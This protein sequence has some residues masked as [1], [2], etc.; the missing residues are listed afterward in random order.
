LQIAVSDFV[1]DGLLEAGCEPT[2]CHTVLN[3]IDLNA[4]H[5]D[6][7]RHAV[8][9][10][11]AVAPSTPVVVTVCRLFE[12]KGVKSLIL[13]LDKVRT[14]VPSATLVVVGADP[15]P[16]QRHVGELRELV[17]QLGLDDF[18]TF[19]GR[20]AVVEGLL[21]ASDIFAMPSFEE[22]FGLVYA[23]AMAM[24]RPVV[25]LDNGG[26]REVVVHGVNGLLSQPGDIDGLAANLA[27]LIADPE[28]RRRL[29]DAARRL[30]EQRFTTDRVAAD[31]SAVYLLVA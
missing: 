9:A 11:L 21:A 14:Q 8:R 18:V 5:P 22:P 29:G 6:R 27:L 15:D 19:T 3:G 17:G 20:R 31:V 23:E 12:E 7:G 16:G 2:H 24:K 13:A 26:T 30:V 25:A 4:W 10:E 28:L 1:R